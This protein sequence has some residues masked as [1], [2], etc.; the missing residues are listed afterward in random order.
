MRYEMAVIGMYLHSFVRNGGWVLKTRL[1]TLHAI[2]FVTS[3]S[4]PVAGSVIAQSGAY[5][6]EMAEMLFSMILSD[7]HEIVLID[8]DDTVDQADL[9]QRISNT[10][11][12]QDSAA[13]FEL[14]GEYGLAVDISNT[15][16][17]KLTLKALGTPEERLLKAIHNGDYESANSILANESVDVNKSV[18]VEPFFSEM[19][20]I[21]L[22]SY[23]GNTALVELLL[24]NGAAVNTV[25][26]NE[27]VLNNAVA[28]EKI[29]MVKLLLSAGASLDRS[30]NLALSA[31][32]SEDVSLMKLLL[33]HGVDPTLIGEKGWTP[34]SQ[35]IMSGNLEVAHLLV[36]LSDPRIV[37]YP[38]SDSTD[39]PVSNALHLARH[40][41]EPQLG[42][43]LIKKILQRT[44]DLGGVS[45]V[46]LLQLRAHKS[47]AYMAYDAL[48]PQ[49]AVEQNLLGLEYV[50]VYSLSANTDQALRT[51]T[52]T[53]LAELHELSVI[54][55]VPF[56]QENRNKAAHLATIE[57]QYAKWHD[58]LDIVEKATESDV[59]DLI[60]RWTTEHGALKQTGWIYDWLLNWADELED[61]T[62]QSRVFDVIAQFRPSIFK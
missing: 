30:Y 62:A 2:M 56:S 21:Y 14:F 19:T 17:E 33:E 52:Q 49:E 18:K 13:L 10:L 25:E 4:V 27:S 43:P 9:K 1:S 7:D 59:T 58:M 8:L 20:P 45:D 51:E 31:A 32:R 53:A 15:S 57:H 60:T 48:A 39:I 42:E 61:R 55:G 12:T 40:V 22:A 35:A 44:E 41:F 5:D 47:A 26:P 6:S 3:L 24:K 28:A 16:T 29:E 36:E 38:I 11:E 34:L 50:D 23:N 46:S 54:A 37:N